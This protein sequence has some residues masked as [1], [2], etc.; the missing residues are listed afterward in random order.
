MHPVRSPTMIL[1]S[2]ALLACTGAALPRED[3]TGLNQ[4]GFITTWLLLAPIPLEEGQTAS[5]ALDKDQLKG[6]A[7][8]QPREGDKVQVG[9]KALAWKKYRAKDYFFD[10]NDLLGKQTEDSVGYAVCYVH[11]DR[12]RKGIQLRTGSDD[13]ARVYLN[14]REVLKQDQARALDKDQDM[15]EVTLNKGTN[16]LVI[17]VINEKEDWSGCARFTDKDGKVIKDLQI[18]TTPK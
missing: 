15:T 1:A 14:G 13:E 11:S 7:R 18:T 9:G 2:A 5:D 3:N 17:K 16:V 10:F 8:L 4:E 6:E 12:E